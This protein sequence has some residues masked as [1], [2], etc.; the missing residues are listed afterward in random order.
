MKFIYVFFIL[1]CCGFGG[2]AH[3]PTFE[4][5]QTLKVNNT[6]QNDNISCSLFRKRLEEKLNRISEA[7]YVN[8]LKKIK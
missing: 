8:Q 4:I 3:P 7:Y 1:I 2:N 5:K 6:D